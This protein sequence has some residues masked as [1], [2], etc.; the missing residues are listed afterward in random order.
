MGDEPAAGPAQEWC[1]TKEWNPVHL[2]GASRG[3]LS[4]I[5]YTRHAAVAFIVRPR[6]P[7]CMSET[8]ARAQEG[9]DQPQVETP[10]HEQALLG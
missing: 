9:N 2:Y 5:Q 10:A 7:P 4:Y 1:M 3:H 8:T 6:M